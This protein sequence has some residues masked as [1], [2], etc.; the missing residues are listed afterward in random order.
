MPTTYRPIACSLHDEYE[1]AI[2]HKK[3]MTIEWREGGAVYRE[4]V[5]PLDILVKNGEEFLVASTEADNTVRIR[6]DRI[7]IL[8]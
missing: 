3:S 5:L 7:A 1:L 4:T 8:D 2:M 6:L